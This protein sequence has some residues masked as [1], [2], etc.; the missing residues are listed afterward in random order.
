MSAEDFGFWVTVLP[1]ETGQ[2]S[3]QRRNLSAGIYSSFFCLFNSQVKMIVN[4][5]EKIES[6]CRKDWE[7][8]NF[9]G[10]AKR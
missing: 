5:K 10:T 2:A 8:H 6:P 3:L 1:S 4:V 9:R 7:L